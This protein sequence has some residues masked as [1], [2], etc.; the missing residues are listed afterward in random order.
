MTGRHLGTVDDVDATAGNLGM[1]KA[2]HRH[3]RRWAGARLPHAAGR[4]QPEGTPEPATGE[5]AI[6][7]G[8][9]VAVGGAVAPA[10]AMP[11]IPANN[12]RALAV[13]CARKPRQHVDP[14]VAGFDTK[15]VASRRGEVEGSGGK[16]SFDQ[17]DDEFEWTMLPPK[18]SAG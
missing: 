17:W 11:V 8:L 3:R 9:V 4:L 18:S 16:F 1:G 6:D 2:G 13:R 15:T 10:L 7:T 5:A 14:S 12:R